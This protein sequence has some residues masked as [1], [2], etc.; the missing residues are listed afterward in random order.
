M[1]ETGTFNA[2]I[3]DSNNVIAKDHIRDARVTIEFGRTAATLRPFMVGY[4]DIFTDRRPRSFYQ[5]YLI[6][7][8]S[9]KIRAAEL[10]LL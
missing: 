4:G 1:S 6:S 7:G 9:S 3:E 10:M 8:P 5:E 2:V